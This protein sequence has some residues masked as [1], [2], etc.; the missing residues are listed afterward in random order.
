MGGRRL[1]GQGTVTGHSSGLIRAQVTLGTVNGRQQRLTTYHHDRDAAEAWIAATTALLGRGDRLP[2]RVPLGDFLAS[3]LA[4]EARDVAPSTAAG[5][6]RIIADMPAQL[7][8]VPLGKLK[9]DHVQAWL[10]GLAGSPRTVAWK[11]NMLRAALNDAIRRDLIDRNPAA[12]ARPPRQRRPRRIVITAAQCSAILTACEARP[13]TDDHPAVPRWRYPAAVAV[14]IGCG[15]RQGEMLGLSW[16]D[17]RADRIVVRQR[18]RRLHGD[19]KRGVPG[20]YVLVAGMKAEEGERVVP[21]PGFARRALAAWKETQDAERSAA[22]DVEPLDRTALPVF[23]T[24]SGGLVNGTTLT[25]G[26]QDRLADAGLDRIPWHALRHATASV[27]AAA[28]VPQTVGRD[29]LG[30]ASMTT[31]GDHYTGSAW[32]Q[33]AAAGA[34]MDAA[35]GQ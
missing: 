23:T 28:K 22:G 33:L 10:D 11:R 24:A 21:L 35:V 18:L 6:A 15:L 26:F 27:L 1:K 34:A 30:H 17:I 9:T 19:R 29:Y 12:S 8:S 5:Y 16:G 4:R 31:T 14:A 13:E 7:A 2:S 3:W 20:E 25:H 32:E